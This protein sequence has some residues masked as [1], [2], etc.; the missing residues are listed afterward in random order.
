MKTFS[1]FLTKAP[2]NESR[3]AG[4]NDYIR[5]DDVERILSTM[6]PG[7]V[8][9]FFTKVEAGILQYLQTTLG[10]NVTDTK[11]TKHDIQGFMFAGGQIRV[12]V[13]RVDYTYMSLDDR[14]IHRGQI[15][16]EEIWI[17]I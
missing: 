13:G 4:P 11:I 5:R 3:L 15:K 10:R 2:L 6:K 12:L 17:N 1:E 9:Q 16:N 7:L 14:Q 8:V